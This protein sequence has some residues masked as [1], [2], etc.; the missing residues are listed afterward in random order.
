MYKCCSPPNVHF[1]PEYKTLAIKPTHSAR[2]REGGGLFVPSGMLLTA[3]ICDGHV[4]L[5]PNLLI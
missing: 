2:M 3:P 5:F 1:P 4:V